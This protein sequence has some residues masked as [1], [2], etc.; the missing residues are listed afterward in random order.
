MVTQDL[1]IL[2]LRHIPNGW[3]EVLSY[4]A[5]YCSLDGIEEFPGT[6]TMRNYEDTQAVLWCVC[7]RY[8]S[9]GLLFDEPGFATDEPY[10]HPAMNE[11]SE[12]ITLV[13]HD[14]ADA[15]TSAW[16]RS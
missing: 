5:V 4:R 9:H 13:R 8:S 6:V 10:I 12:M 2:A 15:G 11:H 14:K 3:R 16:K 1:D 7:S